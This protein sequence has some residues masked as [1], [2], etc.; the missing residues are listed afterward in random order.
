MGNQLINSE[1]KKK[2]KKISSTIIL[3]YKWRDIRLYDNIQFLPWIWSVCQ[4]LLLLFVCYKLWWGLC[5][6]AIINNQVDRKRYF[7]PSDPFKT[8]NG[9]FPL[10]AFWFHFLMAF[11]AAMFN[12]EISFQPVILFNSINTI[13]H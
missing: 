9:N 8:S 5:A 4:S 2:R 10:I 12:R 6:W 1:S 7:L 13:A 11:L 3:L